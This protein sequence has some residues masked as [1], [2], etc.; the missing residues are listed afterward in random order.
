M[1]CSGAKDLIYSLTS[2]ISCRMSW[3]EGGDEEEKHL[4][5]QPRLPNILALR[6]KKEGTGFRLKSDEVRHEE[7][8]RKTR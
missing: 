5:R 7:S 3:S 1:K 4:S 8:T 6:R 2:Q